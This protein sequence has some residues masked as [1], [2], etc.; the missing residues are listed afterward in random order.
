MTDPSVALDTTAGD[1]ALI[2]DLARRAAAAATP[3]THQPIYGDS[4]I[5]RVLRNDETIKTVNLERL[6]S[7]PDRARGTATLYDPTDFS[8]YVNR[9]RTPSTTVWADEKHGRITAVFNDHEETEGDDSGP[10]A[11]WRDHTAVLDLQSDPEW[12]AF[13]QVDGDYMTQAMF[14]EF[15]SNYD[16]SF[17][18]PDGAR[19]LEVATS[20]KAH[21][22]AEF[23]QAINLDNGD[24]QLTYSEET[25]P[26]T[27]RSG[28]IE[29]P[30]DLVVQLTPYLGYPLQQIDARL[31]WYLE[32]SQLRMGF[33]LRRPDIVKRD[34]FADIRTTI[35]DA[36]AE[37]DDT[38]FSTPVL[39]GPPPAPITPFS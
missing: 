36:L 8:E 6:L 10:T 27:T 14:A 35:G 16:T 23:S 30:R 17:V 19:M 38:D 20:F 4:I 24:V 21:R 18:Q 26:K 3:E 34:A 37:V 22:K 31:R 33:K 39:L 11:G 15:L 25:T 28:Q 13:L 1:G 5:T 2:E 29:V 9:L 12:T 7:F 32:G